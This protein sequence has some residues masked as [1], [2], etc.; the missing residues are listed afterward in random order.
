MAYWYNLA[1]KSVEN[2][3]N[4]SQDADVMGPYATEDEARNAL[5]TARKN[6]EKWDAEDREWDEK[7]ATT[8]SSSSAGSSAK[9]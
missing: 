9:S 6:T 5:E 3:G 8:P 7:G 1:T 4:R 2:D